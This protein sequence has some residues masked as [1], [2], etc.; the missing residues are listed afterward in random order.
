MQKHSIGHAGGRAIIVMDSISYIGPEERGTI[1]VSGSHGG[2]AAARYALEQ[3][4]FLAVFND[5]GVGKENAGIIA[6][7]MLETVGVAAAAL[8]HESAR[9]GDGMDAWACGV[10]TH[11]NGPARALGLQPGQ[12]VQEAIAGIAG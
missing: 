6:L 9:I 4:P 7:E 2:A 12:R 3:P 11:V 10:I 5:A 8:S 1:V